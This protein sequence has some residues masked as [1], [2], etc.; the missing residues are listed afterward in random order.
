MVSFPEVAAGE[1]IVFASRVTVSVSV[2][3]IAVADACV[4]TLEIM[5]GVELVAYS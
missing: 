4:N 5:S 1:V 2:V 3:E